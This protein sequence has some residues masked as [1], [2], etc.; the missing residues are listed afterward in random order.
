MSTI[1]CWIAVPH[2]KLG[3]GS[4]CNHEPC[5][6]RSK[7]ANRNRSDFP[8]QGSNRREIP[9]KECNFRSG[10]RS[11]SD[12]NSHLSIAAGHCSRG[13]GKRSNFRPAVESR[14][15]ILKTRDF[16]ALR[17]CSTLRFAIRHGAAS[18][19]GVCHQLFPPFSRCYC[20]P[21]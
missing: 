17:P 2:R 15:R 13:A 14:N 16:G 4:P 5:A 12:G 3:R 18:L 1:L 19:Q 9:Q 20:H 11:A 21:R 10:N 8:S 7:I 6:E